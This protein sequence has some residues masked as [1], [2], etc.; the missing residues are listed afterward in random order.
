MGDILTVLED[1]VE[2]EPLI[3]VIDLTTLDGDDE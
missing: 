2:V 3:L 1:L